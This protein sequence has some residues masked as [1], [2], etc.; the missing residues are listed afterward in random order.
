LEAKNLL[1]LSTK[2]FIQKLKTLNTRRC[3]FVWDFTNEKIKSSHKELQSIANWLM[4]NNKDFLK[5]EGIFLEV[6]KKSNHLFGAF[7]HQTKRGQGQGGVRYWSYNTLEAMLR[8]GL[9]LSAGM[10]RKSALAG[11]WWG[12]G[13]GIVDKQIEEKFKNNEMKKLIF[14]EY[15]EFVTSLKGCFVGA[16]DVG[17]TTQETEWMFQKSRFITCIPVSLGG[18]GNPSEATAKGVVC[19][20]ESALDFLNMGDLNGKIIAMQGTGNVA[21]FMIDELLKKNVK[22]IIATEINDENRISLF[23]RFNNNDKLKIKLIKP[24]D[25]SIFSEKCDIFVPN[26]LGGI[27]NKQTIPNIKAKIVCGAANNQL[28][29]ESDSLLLKEKGITYIPDFVC[30]RMGIVNCSNEQYGKY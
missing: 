23:N 2:E 5:H 10:S 18:S 3:F 21:S 30:N 26:A 24:D 17:I 7:I 15:G 12:G 4:E 11:L 19:A 14:N 25:Q 13:K 22:S 27:L 28:L 16:E 8:D 29:E 9:R 6:G 1:N 20:M